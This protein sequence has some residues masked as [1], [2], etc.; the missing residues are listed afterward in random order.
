[1]PA[2]RADAA[3]AVAEPVI[4]S[5]TDVTDLIASVDADAAMASPG[6]AAAD[7]PPLESAAFESAALGGADFESS[8][9]ESSG[10]EASRFEASGFEASATAEG[11]G[12]PWPDPLLAEY[13]PYIPTPVSLP[14]I[15]KPMATIAGETDPVDAAETAP[16]DEA[17]ALAHLVDVHAGSSQDARELAM[18]VG[19]MER[20]PDEPDPPMATVAAPGVRVSAALERLAER[21][22][23][24]EIDVSSVAAEAPDA[25]V[26][27][28]VLAAL[29]GGSSRR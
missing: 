26:L 16:T 28:S 29:L 10:F 25:A 22:R 18:S 4:A 27:A 12:A 17:Q 14:V 2:W 20:Q 8:G 3:G 9:F 19:S 23:S 1:M 11:C 7:V 13:A 6:E 15:A 5:S 21:V 24:G